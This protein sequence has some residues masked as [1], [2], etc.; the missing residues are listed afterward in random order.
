MGVLADQ[1]SGL[2]AALELPWDR[3]RPPVAS[4]AGEVESFTLSAGLHEQ[5]AELGRM[6]GATV[7]MVLQAGLAVLLT[8]L[9]AGA[10]IPLGV[11]VA[12]RMDQALDDLV[13]FFVNTWVLRADTS[14]DPTFT[15]LL[16]QVRGS[17]LA[18]Y[19]NQDIPFEHVVERLDPVR[20]AAHHPLFQVSLALQDNMPAQFEFPGLE[21]EFVAAYTGRSRFE[22]FVNV[23]EDFA[24][25]GAAA[26]LSGFAEYATALFERSTVQ[27]LLRRW[28]QLLEQLVARPD[29]PISRARMLL[30]GEHEQLLA[31]GGE[32]A[33][34]EATNSTLADLFAD[35]VTRAPETAALVFAEKQ[36][37][38]RGLDHWTNR[39]AHYL[40]EQGAGP[41][42]RV[43]V[44]L[45]RSPLLIASILGV[46]K[47]GAAYIPIDPAYPDERIEFTL[48]DAAPALVLDE[49]WATTTEFDGYS[50]TTPAVAI[51]PADAAY[52]VYTSG[53]TGRPKGVEVTHANVV[54][55]LQA[56]NGSLRPEAGA[57][58]LAA[59]TIGFDMA[60]PE[61]FLPMAAGM[62]M[63][64]AAAGAKRSQR[65]WLPRC[66]TSV[67]RC[68]ICTG[69][70]RPRCGPPPL[71]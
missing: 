7:S 42:Q 17:S 28:G 11:P 65:V 52:V 45:E 64:L 26:G 58:M 15:G 4:Y 66:A 56:M 46:V 13:G 54:A 38:Y 47:S 55:L 40:H 59:T 2:P 18:A 44:V 10:D 51:T 48:A 22:L 1:L 41:G 33:S 60:V 32:G 5:I 68:T 8:R 69:R 9:G 30:E 43:A 16:S 12:G 24:S 62:T 53:S 35:Q 49:H 36:W 29:A 31:W 67:G 63:V 20:S 37:S 23:V 3:P 25:D 19:D 39:I 57:R 21:A 14:G 34:I 27:A 50:G 6:Q 70:P 61:V 71:T